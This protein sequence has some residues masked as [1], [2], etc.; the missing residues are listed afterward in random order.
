[1]S[2]TKEQR[3]ALKEMEGKESSVVEA[4]LLAMLDKMDSQ[5]IMNDLRKLGRY[6]RPVANN[7][8]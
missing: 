5:G 7:N 3:E 6:N 2:L 8:H 4:A 1:M